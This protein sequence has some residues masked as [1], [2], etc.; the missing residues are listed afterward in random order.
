MLWRPKRG[1]LKLPHLDLT[2]SKIV[3]C[4]VAVKEGTCASAASVV[5]KHSTEE[6]SCKLPEAVNAI[7]KST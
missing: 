2:E 7:N 3:C 5:D 1:S 4:P 6:Q